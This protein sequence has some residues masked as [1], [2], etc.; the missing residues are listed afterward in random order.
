M[1]YTGRV[2]ALLL[3]SC[4]PTTPASGGWRSVG[5][6]SVWP[7]E[8]GEPIPVPA[9]LSSFTELSN[10][11]SYGW[12]GV[13]GGRAEQGSFGVG[14]G[15]VF[16]LV[17][18]DNPVNTLTNA[19][20][21]GYQAEAGFFG[22]SAFMLDQT[23]TEAQ[24]QRP[25][26]TAVVRTLELAGDVTLS[27][28]SF[29]TPGADTLVRLVTTWSGSAAELRWEVARDNS[30]LPS[31]DGGITQDRGSKR[32]RMVCETGEIVDDAWVIPVPVGEQTLVCLQQFS[33]GEFPAP[34]FEG[35]LAALDAS[36][37]ASGAMLAE[38]VRL[39][40]PDPKV[41][42]LYEGMLMTEWVQTTEHHLVSPMSRYTRGWLRDAEGPIRLW[43]RAGLHE[44]ALDTLEAVW[45]GQLAA[46]G[47]NN[48]FSLDIEPD[49]I[50]IPEDP[51]D[52]WASAEF[53]PGREPVE[54]PSFP[55]LLHAAATAFTG[56]TFDEQRMAFL[57]ACLDRQE[58]DGDVLAFSGDETFR[59]PM[60]AAVGDLPEELGWSFNSTVLW[61]AAA[62]S[63]GVSPEG[64]PVAPFERD[65]GW[66]PILSFE[67]FP[68]G[69]PYEDV[70]LQPTWW[71][72]SSLDP[73]RLS[74]HLDE[75]AE[76]LLQPDG[77]LLSRLAGT[78]APNI[79]YTGMVPGYWLQAVASA[80]RPEEQ[81]AFDAL[82][83]VAT[84]SG[85]FEELHDAQ[86]LPLSLTH[87]AD[88]LGAD[89]TARYR[90]WEGG[91][92][93][94]AL[95]D[96][97][98]GIEPNAA[99]DSVVL[100][101]HVPQGWPGFSARGLRVGQVRFDLA[102]AAYEEGMVA[103]L[104]GAGA[105]DVVIEMHGAQPFRQV[106]VDGVLLGATGSVVAV[107][108]RETMVGVY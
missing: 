56:Q 8:A 96:Y 95:F 73:G 61:R 92:V 101:P 22:D 85:H 53:M 54:A 88:G 102:M 31:Q 1:A 21:S 106:W 108:V 12:S 24:V 94:S 3:L 81:S 26:E 48:S 64:A 6:S 35:A 65:E 62:Q 28:T 7:N 42:D 83:L 29:A 38:A 52:Y 72:K 45:L 55:V 84:P 40:L 11:S 67:G 17:G 70:S 66:A 99:E 74:S 41:S 71:P 39:D 20:G 82:D 27:T 97:L 100:S 34:D 57:Q 10:P 18:L 107:P 86:H 93:V 103:T 9:A 15:R 43:L 37:S 91:D 16:G 63:L 87:D 2:F 47:V 89:V 79:A 90:P 32:M 51:T 78:N 5:L 46:G 105:L 77:V 44:Q 33:S 80:H 49:E 13:A 14:N 4:A 30:E 69:L 50:E 25:R 104:E 23:V 75:V 98:V 19:M 68:L 36:I 60:S 59:Y 76:H 58:F